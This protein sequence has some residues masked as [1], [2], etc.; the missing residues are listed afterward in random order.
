MTELEDDLLKDCNKKYFIER[1]Y[2]EDTKKTN[3]IRH[4]IFANDSKESEAGNYYNYSTI[5]FIRNIIK[6]YS[7]PRTFDVIEELKEFL[8]QESFKYFQKNDENNNNVTIPIKEENIFIEKINNE[9]TEIQIENEIKKSYLMKIKKIPNLKLKYL[10]LDKI[11]YVRNAFTPPY[12]YYKEFVDED[13]FDKK[14]K[15]FKNNNKKI[16]VL[17]IEIELGGKIINFRSKIFTGN[18]KYYVFITGTKEL[19]KNNKMFD[20]ESNIKENEFRIEFEIDMNELEL[21]NNKLKKWTKKDGILKLYYEIKPK[22]S[23][24]N[25]DIIIKNRKIIKKYNK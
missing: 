11:N 6:R 12:I 5:Q 15:K 23:S 18:G 24:K 1:Y 22:E 9:N 21:K 3:V 10:I 19:P 7:A 13:F 20:Y 14:N 25:E 8:I 4:L 16:E 2:K 17:V